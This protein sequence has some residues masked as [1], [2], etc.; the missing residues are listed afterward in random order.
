MLFAWA[1][2]PRQ[3][4]QAL[5]HRRVAAHW[6]RVR[7]TC[8]AH[9]RPLPPVPLRQWVLSLPKMLR[10]ALAYEGKLCRAVAKTAMQELFRFQRLQARRA[11]GLGSTKQAHTGAMVAV[12]RFGSALNLNIHFHALV[13]AGVFMVDA[14]GHPVFMERAPPSLGDL[15]RVTGRIAEAVLALLRRRHIWLDDLDEN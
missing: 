12:Q 15:H 7:A 1:Y 14:F 6:P 11:R 5:L 4:D 8:A 10:Y 13:L 3:F 9:S 2:Q